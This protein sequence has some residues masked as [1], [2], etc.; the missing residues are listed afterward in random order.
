MCVVGRYYIFTD[1]PADYPLLAFTLDYG[2]PYR[3]E[4]NDMAPADI[5]SVLISC[6]GRAYF[7][8]CPKNWIMA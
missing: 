6:P 1:H 2:I 8:P 5:Q 7:M 3:S 4:T